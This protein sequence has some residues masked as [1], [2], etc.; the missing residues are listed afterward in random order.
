M[1]IAKTAID[2]KMVLETIFAPA[3]AGDDGVDGV[4]DV[5]G[6]GVAISI[7]LNF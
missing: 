4:I 1:T 7:I 3:I 5:V 2:H 6:V